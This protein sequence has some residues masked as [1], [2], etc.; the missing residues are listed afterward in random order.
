VSLQPR[1]A[2]GAKCVPRLNLKRLKIIFEIASSTKPTFEGFTNAI[3][4]ERI[5][6]PGI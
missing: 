1:F 3:R 5:F 2:G 4:S 6:M